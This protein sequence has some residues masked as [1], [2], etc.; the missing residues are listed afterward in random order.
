MSRLLLVTWHGGGNVNPLLVLG[1]ALV[2][3]G[4]DVHG[5]IPATLAPRFEAAGLPFTEHGGGWGEDLATDVADQLALHPCHAAVVDYMMTGALCGAELTGVPTVAFVHTLYTGVADGT[6][7]PMEMAGGIE[8]VNTWRQALQLK[9]L[10]Q[11]TDLLDRS[12]LVLVT[13]TPEL[14]G[15]D[16]YPANVQLVGPLVA[17]ER[18]GADEPGPRYRVVAN[19]GTTPMDEAPLARRLAA[20]LGQLD[21]PALLTVGDHLDPSTIDAPPD[22][23]VSGYVPHGQVL[24]GADLFISH[25]GLSGIG[26]ALA[27]GVPVLCLPLGRDQPDNAARLAAV[28]AGRVL[29]PASGIDELRDAIRGALDD[30]ALRDGARRQQAA[31]TSAGGAARAVDAIEAALR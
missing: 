16:T 3:H 12:R 9:P 17:P 19:L 6:A 20:A 23:T 10:E 18:R 31:A 11:V 29:D 21:V 4:H 24:P 8:A 13:A 2:A 27:H 14:D 22:V 26:T 30:P 7:S 28:G 1:Q 5:L 15:G 25:G